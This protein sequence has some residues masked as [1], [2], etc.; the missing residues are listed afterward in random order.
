VQFPF[1]GGVGTNFGLTGNFIAPPFVSMIGAAS[2]G[3]GNWGGASTFPG[4]GSPAGSILPGLVLTTR[5]IP[6]NLLS[7]R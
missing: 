2:G 5:T 4:I 3:G 7:I 1:V 6:P